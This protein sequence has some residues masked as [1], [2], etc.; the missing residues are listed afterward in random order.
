MQYPFNACNETAFL[1]KCMY[2]NVV[3]TFKSETLST[4]H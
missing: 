2:A 3:R 4:V 1:S